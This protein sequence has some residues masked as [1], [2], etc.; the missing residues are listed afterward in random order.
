M[1]KKLIAP[2]IIT[3]LVVLYQIGMIAAFAFA[4]F[5]GMPI[6]IFVLLLI[7]PAAAA[8]AMIYMLVQRVKE[9]KGG[10]EDEASKY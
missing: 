9:I 5:E 7:I 1:K 2:I 10:E 8:A 4:V 6:W 3:V